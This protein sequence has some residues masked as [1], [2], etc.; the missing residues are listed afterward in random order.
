MTEPSTE[1]LDLLTEA[2]PPRLLLDFIKSD[3]RLSRTVLLGFSARVASV[4]HPL[5]RQRLVRE[6]AKSTELTNA[7]LSLWEDYA[8]GLL[9]ALQ[10]PEFVPGPISLATLLQAYGAAALSY[11]LLH[12]ER[13]ELQEWADRLTEI[14][15]ATVDR[16][17]PPPRVSADRH[18]PAASYREKVFELQQKLREVERE[19]DTL[20]GDVARLEGQVRMAGAQEAALRKLL[21]S[22]EA[23]AEREQRRVRKSE[24]ELAE[25]QKQLRQ[26]EQRGTALETTTSPAT[27]SAEASTVISDAITLLQRG[28]KM[29]QPA[30]KSPVREPAPAA[31]VTPPSP[32]TK[33]TPKTP[34]PSVSLPTAQGKHV[35]PVSQILTALQRNDLAT[36]DKVRDGIARLAR[37]PVKEQEI[38][39]YL[40]K[41]GIPTTVLTGP[42]RPALVDG[43]NIANMSPE[44]RARLGYLQQVQRA[45]WV[46]GYFPVIVIV[47]ASL[48]HQIDQPDVLLEMID[49]GDI[50]MAPAGTSADELLI[51]EATRLHAVLITNDRMTNWP[52]AKS[53][54]KRHVTLQNGIARVGGFHRST[55]LFN[56]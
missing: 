24:A 40:E 10:A 15:S 4:L 29:T 35:Y 51:A 19:R 17:A 55:E 45:A 21:Q 8:G 54:E 2:L 42:L 53:V 26:L 14:G 12:A 23:H 52:D 5:V 6:V 22:T 33:P 16:P 41:A 34:A 47:D 28:L 38:L 18:D 25:L 43:S 36:I 48:P 44:R 32:P 7:L 39:E 56:W 30:V 37:Q 49:R 3:E 13:E 31:A 50:H 11:A 1:P 46:E 20:K 27:L 9:E